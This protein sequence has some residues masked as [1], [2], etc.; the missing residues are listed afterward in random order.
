MQ[1]PEQRVG[2]GKGQ[3]PSVDLFSDIPGKQE[4]HR[5]REMRKNPLQDDMQPKQQCHT[6]DEALFALDHTVGEERD[7]TL[8]DSK[9]YE[10]EVEVEGDLYRRDKEYRE[11]QDGQ[12][13][14]QMSEETDTHCCED[15]EDIVPVRHPGEMIDLPEDLHCP[16]MSCQQYTDTYTEEKRREECACKKEER[17]GSEKCKDG[18]ITTTFDGWG[19]RE[20]WKCRKDEGKECRGEEQK[21]DRIGV[22]VRRGKLQN[23]DPSVGEHKE[24]HG[25]DRVEKSQKKKGLM[26]L[27]E[28]IAVFHDSF[29][30]F[31]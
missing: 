15:P 23:D 25:E 26:R 21:D 20:A 17:R 10:K 18:E 6:P 24:Q 2:M 16:G 19:R 14:Q 29:L 13:K 9:T 3:P 7:H 5:K 30:F 12:G 8:C 28:K 22:E 4:I 31:S 11:K 27:R 1:Y